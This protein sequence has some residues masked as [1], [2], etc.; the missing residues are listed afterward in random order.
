MSDTR[1]EADF[2]AHIEQTIATDPDAEWIFI[3]DQLNTHKSETLVKL[4]A[5]ACEI[6]DDLGQ[7]RRTGILK[8]MT[9]RAEFLQDSSHRIRF[10][11]T[12]KHCSWLNQVEIWFSILTRRLLKRGQFA[13]TAELKQQILAF[14]AYH[15]EVFAKPFRWTYEGKPLMQ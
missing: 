12:P 1:K 5:E 8:N 14:I 11:Y 3:C 9:T 13:S 6:T 4:V 10:V 15:N 7:K 2:A